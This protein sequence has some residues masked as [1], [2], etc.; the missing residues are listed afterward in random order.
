MRSPA[1]PAVKDAADEIRS[2][3]DV[4]FEPGDVAEVRA[5]D[6]TGRIKS[7]YF[8]DHDALA[9]AAAELDRRGWQVYVTLNPV[10]K[11]L[12]VQLQ[13]RFRG[14]SYSSSHEI[15]YLRTSVFGKG[16]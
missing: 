2:T 10:N 12:L 9:G 11:T 13:D 7:G 6:P 14:V 5:F 3:V 15:S 16:V 1:R 8:D 4:L